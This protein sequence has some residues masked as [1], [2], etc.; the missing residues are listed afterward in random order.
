[1][2]A[3][4]VEEDLDSL[5]R[6]LPQEASD[7]LYLLASGYDFAQ[8]LE[9]LSAPA[10]KAAVDTAD[11][12]TA[13]ERPGSLRQFKVITDDRELAEMLDAPLSLWRVFLHPTQ[14]QLVRMDS[15]GGVDEA[16]GQL[17]SATDQHIGYLLQG[18]SSAVAQALV[19]AL[20]KHNARE[21]DRRALLL[22]YSAVEPALTNEHCSFW[23]F[24]FDAHAD[25]RLAALMTVLQE[26]KALKRAYL[27]GQDY[28]F[29]QQVL[30]SARAQIAARRPDIE[31]VGDELH[32]MGRV[33]D[34]L[35][36]ATKIR[37]SGA[38]AVV[39]GNW[40]NDLT[41]LVK[42]VHELGLAPKFYTFYGN[43]LG[44]PAALGDAG[45]G[46]VLAVAE[47][48]PNLGNAPSD[49]L[50]S[51][52]RKRF[53]DPRDD[54]LHARMQAMVELL[55][56]AA[57]K[58]RSA[59]PAAVARALEGLRLDASALGGMHE[60]SMRAADHQLQ[61]PL[62][63]AVMDKVGTPGVKFDVEGSGYGFRPLRRFTP[64]QAELPTSCR[65]PRPD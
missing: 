59:E 16:L 56:Q 54:Y 5:A 51:A 61:Q 62:V 2:R 21:P 12:T 39:T 30:K 29:G 8:A 32:P 33:K 22:N 11:F 9:E 43:A 48:F 15:K 18:N 38:Q 19:S 26:D 36:Y 46:R 60:A 6:F 47:W 41:L 50:V 52:F 7:A 37:A 44:V 64:A 27:I 4:R 28:S 45:V 58:A 10:P 35:P 63:V 42:A 34:F 57:E 14:Q 3:V 20:D 55:V 24:R 40:G 49:A 17:R 25:M 13:L 53:A 31:I 1:M 65:M 23:H